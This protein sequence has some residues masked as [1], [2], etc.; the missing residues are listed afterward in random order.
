MTPDPV[1]AAALAGSGDADCLLS[2]YAADVQTIRPPRPDTQEDNRAPDVLGATKRAPNTAVV[3]AIK[4]LTAEYAA[5][6]ARIAS[7]YAIHFVEDMEIGDFWAAEHDM[8]CAV[9]HLREAAAKFREWQDKPLP[10][11]GGAP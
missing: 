8:R 6:A 11:R 2:S 1:C 5:E 3:A 10:A 9:L 4:D 7:I